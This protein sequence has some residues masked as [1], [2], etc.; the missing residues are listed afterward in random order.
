MN[1]QNLKW[2]LDKYVLGPIQAHAPEISLGIGLAGT[3]AGTILACRATAHAGLIVDKTQEEL[4]DI[5]TAQPTDEELE[6]MQRI[7]MRML[8]ELVKLY[9]LP[10]CVYAG[11]VAFTLLSHKLQSDRIS[12]LMAAYG[13]LA[14]S[15]AAYQEKVRGTFGEDK[16]QEMLYG[17]SE[18]KINK[19]VEDGKEKISNK[20][21]RDKIDPRNISPY[22]RFFDEACKCWDPEF[23]VTGVN[24]DY[25]Y[26]T[27][28]L[29][30]KKLK[31]RGYLFLNEV[32]E[33]FDI[34][35]TQEGQVVG[36]IYDKSYGGDGYVDIGLYSPY[37]DAAR[38]FVNGLEKAILLD[39]NVDGVIIDKID[40]LFLHK[41][42]KNLPES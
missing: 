9:I 22:A 32:Y 31:V 16:E 18:K 20:D 40:G 10:A 23:A 17:T 39:F 36:W 30:N 41:R 42:N 13:A 27:Q 5:E 7:K 25:A 14:T 34:P 24:F 33:A 11:G 26:C 21:L 38:R 8:K 1:F 3:L 4:D 29:M 12:S 15:Y 37:N 19:A 28:E 35:P 2:K 6:E